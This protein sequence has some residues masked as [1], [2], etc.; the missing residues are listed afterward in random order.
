M[1][2]QIFAELVEK[3]EII[4]GVYKFGVKASEIV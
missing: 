4:K 1:S 3:E 2:K